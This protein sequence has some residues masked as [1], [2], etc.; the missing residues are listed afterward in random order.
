MTEPGKAVSWYEFQSRYFV[1]GA[2]ER[3]ELENELGVCENDGSSTFEL[4]GTL[5]R[6]RRALHPKRAGCGTAVS[7]EAK[8]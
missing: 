4:H 8:Q 6:G 2:E 7:D 1:P 5:P 3:E